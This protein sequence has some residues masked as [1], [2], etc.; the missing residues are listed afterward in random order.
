M[1][2]PWGRGSVPRRCGAAPDS[3]APPD[4]QARCGWWRRKRCRPFPKRWPWSQPARRCGCNP[5]R[6]LSVFAF[7]GQSSPQKA[8][9]I[10]FSTLS[11]RVLNAV[12]HPCYLKSMGAGKQFVNKGKANGKLLFPEAEIALPRLPFASA[13]RI[14]TARASAQKSG[15]SFFLCIYDSGKSACR[16]FHQAHFLQSRAQGGHEQ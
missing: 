4:P 2:S 9:Q 1:E 10:M 15:G 7:S 6:Q 8:P 14:H 16:S 13:P 11:H 12:Y 3:P 5:P